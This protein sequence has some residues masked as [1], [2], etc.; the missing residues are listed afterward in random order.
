MRVRVELGPEQERTVMRAVDALEG[1]Q[2]AVEGGALSPG[3]LVVT[4]L[5]TVVTQLT[6]IASALGPDPNRIDADPTDDASLV[7]QLRRTLALVTDIRD[8]LERGSPRPGG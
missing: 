4:G 3:G 2:E 5:P 7:G 8:A 6:D 1:A